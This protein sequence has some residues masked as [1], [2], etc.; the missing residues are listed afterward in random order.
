[1]VGVLVHIEGQDRNAPGRGLSVIVRILI[2]EPPIPRD[3]DQQYPSGAAGQALRHRNELTAPAIHRSEVAGER[4]SEYLG[5]PSIAEC[6]AAKYS[7]WSNV[8]LSAISCSRFK[9][10]TT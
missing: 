6:H 7:S 8:E 9:L 10:L 5:R 4:L 2:D 3:I 1:M